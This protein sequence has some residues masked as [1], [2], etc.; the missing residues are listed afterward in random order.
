MSDR[1]MV[2]AEGKITG[3]LNAEEANSVSVMNLAT[4][5]RNADESEAI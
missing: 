5:F 1:V 3:I 4:Q 2:M